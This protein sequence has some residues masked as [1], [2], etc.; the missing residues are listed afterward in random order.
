MTFCYNCTFEIWF[1]ARIVARGFSFSFYFF[2][3][4]FEAEMVVH[5]LL[6]KGGRHPENYSWPLSRGLARIWARQW[7]PL[8]V[9]VITILKPV[10]L[11]SYPAH[12]PY[13]RPAEE[14]KASSSFADPPVVRSRPVRIR[15]AFEELLFYEIII[16]NNITTL[17]EKR[18]RKKEEK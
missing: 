14:R 8:L 6:K 5:S 3:F 13:S 15:T 4:E 12:P 11:P 2:F 1:S 17:G 16:F 10:D 7:P 9:N 18:S